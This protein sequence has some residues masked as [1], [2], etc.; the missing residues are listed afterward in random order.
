MQKL[1]QKEK[2]FLVDVRN[3]K[4]FNKFKIPN[5]INIPLSFIKTKP[6]LKSHSVVLVHEGHSYTELEKETETLNQNGFDIK[7]LEGGLWAW[8]HK[9]GAIVGDPF[10]QQDL[11]KISARAF[12][13][14]KDYDNWVVIDASSAPS[15]KTEKLL[16][17]AIR[18]SGSENSPKVNELVRSLF[19]DWK[20]LKKYQKGLKIP[21][22]IDLVKAAKTNPLLFVVVTT[23]TGSEYAAL[24][25]EI[26]KACR[27]RVFYLAGGLE[28][29]EEFLN[30]KLLANRPRNERVKT[31]EGCDECEK[32]N[33]ED[34]LN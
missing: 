5:S 22:G 18:L 4:D 32:E 2:I 34:K 19:L 1:E 21:K 7:I 8:K 6:F 13:Q 28:A 30:F 9:G 23:E 15:G 11:N 20:K 16:P 10:S 14:E 31:T 26:D 12:F 3:D 27:D 33:L 17:K 24:E 25:N 29:Y